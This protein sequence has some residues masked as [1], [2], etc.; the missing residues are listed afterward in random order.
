MFQGHSGV[1]FFLFYQSFI[2][3]K[4]NIKKNTLYIKNNFYFSPFQ[5]NNSFSLEK[6]A[7]TGD[8]NA[9]FIMR[10][11][12]FD[13]VAKFLEIKSINPKSKQSEI[14]EELAISTSTLQRYEKEIITNSPYGI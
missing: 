1:V 12:K 11:I 8:L 10:Q 6:I 5:M 3:W 4:M 14:A 13:R 7:K 9:D 2:F